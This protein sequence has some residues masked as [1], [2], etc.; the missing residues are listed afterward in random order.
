MHHREDARR[1]RA[2][3]T[4]LCASVGVCL[5]EPMA[6]PSPNDRTGQYSI[7]VLATK[8]SQNDLLKTECEPKREW[9]SVGS[10][11]DLVAGPLVNDQM[12]T[13]RR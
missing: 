12:P 9:K 1:G 7:I 5:C 6:H 2:I 3:R 4:L 13:K 10:D 8:L 11:D